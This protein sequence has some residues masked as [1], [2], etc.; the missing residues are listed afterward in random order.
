MPSKTLDDLLSKITILYVEDEAFNRDELSKFFK[1]RTGNLIVAVNG[2]DG[3]EKFREHKPDLVIT[4]LKMP[5]MGGLEMIKE[6]R[7]LGSNVPVIIISALSDSKTIL[8][9]VDIGILKYVVK[10]INLRDLLNT[11]HDAISNLDTKDEED[12]RNGLTSNLKEK[13]FIEKSIKSEFAHF[14]KKNTGK[15]PLDIKVFL[16]MKE[17]E[18][19]ASGILTQYELSIIQNDANYVL[20]DYLREIFY[21]ESSETLIKSIDNIIKRSS[22]IKLVSTNS[23]ENKDTITIKF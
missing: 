13:S 9:A 4:D 1:R 21:M 16:G 11:V 18:I 12:T 3:L 7:K 23:K 20:I 5:I 19:I 15:G 22:Q 14:L 2:L 10:P 6:I 8:N 17:I